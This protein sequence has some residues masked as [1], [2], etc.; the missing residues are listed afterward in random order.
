MALQGEAL[1]EIR[2]IVASAG[3]GVWH[4]ELING[5]APRMIAD[6]T[7]KELLGI[8]GVELTPEE[9]Y[10][11][12]FSRIKP[13]AVASVLDSVGK[14]E[15]G[16]RDENTYL[17]I[18]PTKGERYVRCG[19]TAKKVPGGFVLR[20]YHYD[21]DELVRKDR[22]KDAILEAVS[23][24][25][26]T[27][28]MITKADLTMHFIRSNGVTTIQNAVNMGRGN[29]NYDAAMTKYVN[30]YVVEED[31]ERVAEAVKSSVIMK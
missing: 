27:M 18:H 23:T 15:Q 13:G 9:T 2:E 29:A 1:N 20:G 22:E 21:V 26:H 28:W 8:A 25:Y 6:D 17:W 14:M 11:E 7:M 4:I 16:L 24:E 10:T 31:R 5:Q 12:W 30:T 3:M 19:G